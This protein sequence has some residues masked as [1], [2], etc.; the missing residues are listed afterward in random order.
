MD[1]DGDYEIVVGA[2]DGH[3]YM[4]H[5]DGTLDPGFPVMLFSEGDDVFDRTVSSPALGDLDYR[6]LLDELAGKVDPIVLRHSDGSP[7]AIS[8][9]FTGNMPIVVDAQQVLLREL[10]VSYLTAFAIIA[11]GAIVAAGG[12]LLPYRIRCDLSWR[13]IAGACDGIGLS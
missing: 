4:W 2:M 7:G 1:G 6:I 9:M 10:I 12:D 13:R 5:H 11:V 8:A 3:V